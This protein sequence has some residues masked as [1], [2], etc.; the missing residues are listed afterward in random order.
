MCV[1]FHHLGLPHRR[2]QHSGDAMHRSGWPTDNRLTPPLLGTPHRKIL[3]ENMQSKGAAGSLT[4][5]E[6][7]RGGTTILF[8]G[9]GLTP[10]ATW[11]GRGGTSSRGGGGCT[12]HT[13]KDPITAVPALVTTLAMGHSSA[14]H[15]PPTPRTMPWNT[16]PCWV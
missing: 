7:G 10:L 13:Q 5:A 9:G 1:T 12:L 6:L 2:G 16:L 8:T 3:Q 11:G 15:K 4:G 14:L